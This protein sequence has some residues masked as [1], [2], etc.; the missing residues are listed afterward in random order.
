MAAWNAVLGKH[1]RQAGVVDDAYVWDQLG[2]YAARDRNP[3]ILQGVFVLLNPRTN[4]ERPSPDYW[5]RTP[6][7]GRLCVDG[8][9]ITS[10]TR[11]DEVNRD[12]RAPYFSRGYLD[13]HLQL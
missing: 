6:F 3:E 7:K 13:A 2:I 5:P 4:P 11:L 8:S 12:K 10:S 9:V 1:S